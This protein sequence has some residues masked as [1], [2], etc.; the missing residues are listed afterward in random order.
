MFS[1]FVHRIY[2]KKHMLLAKPCVYLYCMWHS[3][4]SAFMCL[5]VCICSCHINT[6]DENVVICCHIVL[7]LSILLQYE[8]EKTEM[9]HIVLTYQVV[10]ICKNLSFV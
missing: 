1:L 7:S 4:Q 3:I 6:P 2:Y 10:L 5:C 9:I 8:L